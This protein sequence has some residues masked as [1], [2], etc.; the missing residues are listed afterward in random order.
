MDAAQVPSPSP[1]PP[2]SAGMTATPPVAPAAPLPTVL[3]SPPAQL[4]S[5]LQAAWP[6]A[7]QWATA[8]ILGVA[9]TLL[10]FHVFSSTRASSKPTEIIERR[11]IVEADGRTREVIEVEE[12][13]KA[14]PK[15]KAMGK[16]EAMLKGTIDV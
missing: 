8:F 5:P 10:A 11:V 9:T 14:A 15:R 1:G 12:P 16:K 13:A 4:L 6:P 3:P 2:A 7:A